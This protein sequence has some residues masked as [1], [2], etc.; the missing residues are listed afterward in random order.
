M[1]AQYLRLGVHVMADDIEVI[2]AA[3]KLLKWPL[4][5]VNRLARHSWLRS[6][7]QHHADSREQ[8]Q[9]IWEAM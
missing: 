6:I 4:N 9:H 5:P 8:A 7:L 1:Y 3:L 2:R